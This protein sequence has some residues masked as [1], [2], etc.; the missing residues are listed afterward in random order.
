MPMTMRRLRASAPTAL[1]L[2]PLALAAG[3]CSDPNGPQAVAL[4]V[5]APSEHL[6]VGQSLRLSAAPKDATGDPVRGGRIAWSSSDPAV[7]EVGAEG[8]VTGR[9]P[10]KVYVRAALGSVADSV[11]LTVE[12]PVAALEVFPDSLFLVQG[13][14]GRVYV[15]MRDAAGNP[16]A[17]SLSF[18]SSAA[19]TAAVDPSGEVRGASPGEATVTVT[20]GLRQVQ[21]PVRVVTGER[22]RVRVLEGGPSSW[23]PFG[24]NDRGEVVGWTLDGSEQSVLW[25]R[26]RVTELGAGRAW[27]VNDSGTVVLT[28]YQ[29][30]SQ[31]RLVLW[32]DGRREL[33]SGSLFSTLSG[34]PGSLVTHRAGIARGDRVVVTASFQLGP[35][36]YSTRSALW[37]PQGLTVL[38]GHSPPALNARGEVAINRGEHR[39]T[40]LPMR[41]LVWRNGDTTAVPQPRAGVDWWQIS[42]INDQGRAVGT[43][44]VMSSGSPA[45]QGW[46]L[47]DGS[48]ATDL[49]ALPGTPV[50]INDHGDILGHD[51]E[52]TVVVRG[53]RV[54]DLGEQLADWTIE[55]AFGINDLGQVVALGRHRAT[56]Q[57]RTLLLTPAS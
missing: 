19:G 20:A 12:D 22:Y 53:T 26:G 16:V 54:V 45:A 31:L 11:Q 3:G 49:G 40:F 15:E 42:A 28:E 25:R 6:D 27:A 36:A 2:L 10:G 50:A 29:A 55:G 18:A 24:I 23:V 1:A 39:H 46:Y 34:A 38:P 47:W 5:S 30:P 33:A 56:G 37:T 7:A 35:G 14:P 13:R 4:E 43:Y 8:E 32:R 52:R 48:S 51:A 21:V 17:H 44:G 9:A 41:A 57:A